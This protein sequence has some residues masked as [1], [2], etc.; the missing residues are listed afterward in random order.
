MITVDSKLADIL[1]VPE[2]KAI[3]DEVIPG[4]SSNPMVGVGKGMGI[5]YLMKYPQA[6]GLGFTKEAVQEI[7]DRIN[8]L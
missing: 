5:K 1:D 4:L 3:F 7:L 8:A 6:K 2:Y